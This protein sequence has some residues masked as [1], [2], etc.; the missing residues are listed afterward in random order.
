MVH[1]IRFAE[2]VASLLLQVD[3]GRIGLWLT[4]QWELDHVAREPLF[5]MSTT[6]TLESHTTQCSGSKPLPFQR[7][8]DIPR[9]ESLI[10]SKWPLGILYEALT[11][12]PATTHGSRI[13]LSQAKNCDACA[14][15]NLLLPLTYTFASFD[16]IFKDLLRNR[17]ACLLFSLILASSDTCHAH[18]ESLFKSAR[19][20]K[21]I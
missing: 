13:K 18:P 12:R 15:N 9:H 19:Q 7:V 14:A 16:P 4:R 1:S 6:P 2:I 10:K 21:R 5:S 3:S 11:L 17:I 20:D 8:H